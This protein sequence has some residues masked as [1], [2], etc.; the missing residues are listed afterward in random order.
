MVRLDALE[1]GVLLL[2]VPLLFERRV[3]RRWLASAKR[4]VYLLVLVLVLLLMLGQLVLPDAQMS[5]AL[6]L[7]LVGLALPEALQQLF[8]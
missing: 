7:Q 1:T 2:G 3:R 4:L 8:L 5:C 6:L